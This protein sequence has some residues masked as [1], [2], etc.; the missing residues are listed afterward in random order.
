MPEASTA[1]PS[2]IK[3]LLPADSISLI[4]R[5]GLEDHGERTWICFSDDGGS[6]RCIFNFDP[7]HEFHRE[8]VKRLTPE[9]IAEFLESDRARSSPSVTKYEPWRMRGQE[10]SG[11]I[12]WVR[13]TSTPH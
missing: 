5:H 8:L 3:N 4:H 10:G 13:V 2:Q 6:S 7:G 1:L 12:A 9:K 11:E